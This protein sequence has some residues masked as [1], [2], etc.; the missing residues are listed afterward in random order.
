MSYYIY[1]QKRGRSYESNKKKQ[2][3]KTKKKRHRKD[4][5][6]IRDQGN[7]TENKEDIRKAEFD[8][9]S[10]LLEL[11]GKPTD[12]QKKGNQ[13]SEKKIIMEK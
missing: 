6:K 4:T 8:T 5:R 1:Y 2:K 10:L 12:S 3:K 13:T 9:M 7:Q 11:K